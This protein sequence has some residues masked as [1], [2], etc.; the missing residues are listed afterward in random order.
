MS[1][2]RS[3]SDAHLAARNH[4]ASKKPKV[5]DEKKI[6]QPKAGSSNDPIEIG[7]DSEEEAHWEAGSIEVSCRLLQDR[8]HEL[9]G[10]TA[11]AEANKEALALLDLIGMPDLSKTYQFNFAVDLDVFLTHLHRDAVRRR[12]KIVFVTG[13]DVVQNSDDAEF[14]KKAFDIEE[15]KANLPFR[16]GSHHSKMMQKKDT[17][18]STILGDRFL[19]D[20]TEYLRSYNKV[21]ISQ[22]IDDIKLYDYLS[23][24]IEILLSSPGIYNLSQGPQQ[25]YGKFLQLLKRNDLLLGDSDANHNVLAQVSS[26]ASSFKVQKGQHASVFT[27]LICPLM[28]SKTNRF[29]SLGPSENSA[30]N[31]QT[32]YNYTP[33][34]VYP[35]LDEVADS[36]LG[37]MSG[38]AIHFNNNNAR[39]NANYLQN[40]KPYLCKWNSSSKNSKTGRENVMPHTKIYAC[41]NADNWSSLRWALVGSHNLSKQAW[42]EPLANNEYRICSYELSIFVHQK[43]N[44]KLIPVYA[45]DSLQNDTH[46]IPIRLPFTLPPRRYLAQDRP[47]SASTASSRRDRF[48]NT[49]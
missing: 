6:P 48:G 40:I 43:E 21:T 10:G 31:H 17:S 25:G 44:R 36:N 34:I 1:E 11:S 42:G 41:D 16:F 30:R 18:S 13:S 23:I 5:D 29:S 9:H 28:F 26:I 37:Y 45:S 22:L 20:M 24:D 3:Q 39:L 19:Q 46:N 33:N 27:H 38:V 32:Q 12:A 15:V 14:V 2:K 35:T 8:S 49:N 47:W 7:D 4:W